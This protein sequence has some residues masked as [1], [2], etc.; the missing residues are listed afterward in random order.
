MVQKGSS[1]TQKNQNAAQP[2]PNYEK[3]S[4]DPLKFVTTFI[5]KKIRNLDKRKVYYQ[6]HQFLLMNIGSLTLDQ[7][8]TRP[9]QSGKWGIW[10]GH[11]RGIPLTS[12]NL[13]GVRQLNYKMQTYKD[14]APRQELSLKISGK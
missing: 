11:S 4:Q 8:V 6:W 7:L 5:E 12:V 10:E 1:T 3:I 2:P 14:C 13:S 9:G